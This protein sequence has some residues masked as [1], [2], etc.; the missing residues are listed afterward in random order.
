MTSHQLMA[1][2]SVSARMSASALL[3]LETWRFQTCFRW[4]AEVSAA[5]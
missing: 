2:M 1:R 3:T 4:S 5:D